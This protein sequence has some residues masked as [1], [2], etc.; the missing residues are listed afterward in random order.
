MVQLRSIDSLCSRCI[1]YIPHRAVYSYGINDTF[2][3]FFHYQNY[4]CTYGGNNLT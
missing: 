1:V 2:M 4:Y 3:Y